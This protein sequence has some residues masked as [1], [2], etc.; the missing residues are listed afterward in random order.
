[1]NATAKGGAMIAAAVLSTL[2]WATTP[3]ASGASGKQGAM[4]SS[5]SAKASRDI[6]AQKDSRLSKCAAMHGDEQNGCRANAEATANAARKAH[7][8]AASVPSG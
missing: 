4:T 1:M 7:G 8:L 6:E 2:T 5:K 3:A